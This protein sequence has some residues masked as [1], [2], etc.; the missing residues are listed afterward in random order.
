MFHSRY[1]PDPTGGDRATTRGM[2]WVNRVPTP[3]THQ[4]PFGRSTPEPRKTLRL[5]NAKAKEHPERLDIDLEV[6]ED[7]ANSNRP[8]RVFHSAHS[9]I[10]DARY[11]GM[12]LAM[13]RLSYGRI[14]IR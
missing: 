6:L 14:Y 9:D 7:A 3:A 1:T 5:K 11:R 10:W 12:Q 13:D 8:Y 4:E 2:E